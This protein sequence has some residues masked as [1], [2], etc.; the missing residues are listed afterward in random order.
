MFQECVM[1]ELII[2]LRSEHSKAFSVSRVQR[3][4]ESYQFQCSTMYRP[5]KR[6]KLVLNCLTLMTRN[7]IEHLK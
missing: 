1:K 3:Q 5:S 7:I 4:V 2:E 6:N